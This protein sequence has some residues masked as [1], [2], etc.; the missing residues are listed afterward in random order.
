M[1]SL[2]QS[3]QSHRRSNLS[4]G[5]WREKQTMILLLTK[6]DGK[7]AQCQCMAQPGKH[8]AQAVQSLRKR[9][10]GITRVHKAW[11]G[12]DCQLNAERCRSNQCCTNL[13]LCHKHC[14]Q[15]IIRTPAAC[16]L[17]T[18]WWLDDRNSDRGMND[19]MHKRCMEP[20]S[21]A[22]LLLL[23]LCCLAVP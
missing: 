23:E 17:T 14:F 11:K 4:R 5:A 15:L 2:H 22:K 9:W 16:K 6:V 7:P 8:K 1:F 12:S 18:H 21:P 3:S 19:K 10:W 13:S 20:L